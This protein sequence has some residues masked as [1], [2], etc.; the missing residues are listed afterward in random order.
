MKEKV[1]SNQVFFFAV[2]FL[3]RT[4]FLLLFYSVLFLPLRSSSYQSGLICRLSRLY[5]FYPIVIYWFC[6]FYS[7]SFTSFNF[8]KLILNQK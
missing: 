5:L 4:F 6:L 2:L 1:C 3:A 7:Y 8:A